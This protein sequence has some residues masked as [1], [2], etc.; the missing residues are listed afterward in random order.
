VTQG[1]LALAL[2][3][4]REAGDWIM[5]WFRT[6]AEVHHKGPDQPV[7]EADLVADALLADRLSGARP[8][9][10]WLSEET[11]DRGDRLDRARVWLVDPLDGTRS[12][13]AGYREFAVSV[14]LVEEGAVVLGVVYNPSRRDLFWAV[15]GEGAYRAR[16]WAGGTGGGRRLRVREPGRGGRPRLLAS[17]TEIRRGELEPFRAGWSIRPLG[18]TAYKLA[19][20]AARIGH[21]FL[22]LGPKSEWDVAAGGLLVEEAGGVMT[23]L[24]GSRPRYNGPD[25]Y[26]HGVL[27]APPELHART[28]EMIADLPTPR[29]RAAG[30]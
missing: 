17:R 14:G 15:R 24:N 21:G 1:D 5:G 25:P 29:L 8:G 18:S 30:G 23:D 4:A 22:S 26:V 20:V 10:G 7:T 3:A 6:G 16:P 12:F 19:A 13:V 11:V 2:E 9:Y 27:A 28:L